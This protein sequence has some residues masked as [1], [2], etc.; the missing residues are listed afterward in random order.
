MSA[1]GLFENARFP[2]SNGYDGRW[3]AQNQMGPNVL[4][5]TEWLTEAMDLRPG[6]KVLDLGCGRALS[7]IFLAR[8]FGVTVFATDLWIH[9]ADN[10][11]RIRAAGSEDLVFPFRA[12][13][14]AL[15]FAEGFFDAIVSLDSYQYY[16]TDDL[17]AGYVARYL[18]PGGHLGIVVPG[19]TAEL[20]AGPPEHL[21]RPQASGKPFWEPECFSF[22]S[23]DWWRRHWERSGAVEV[24]FA[25]DLA[26]GWQH[27]ADHEKALEASGLGV[28]PSDEE[29][30][31]EDAGRTIAL[32]RVIGRRPEA[33]TVGPAPHAWEP[34]FSSVVS[35]LLGD[36]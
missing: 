9:A 24:E 15:P 1:A 4:W 28:F 31:R 29:A 33:A 10:L 19:L 36:R 12:E 25:G 16:G 22:H 21:L 34:A 32:V 20:E 5:L 23:A 35:D 8:E 17:Y 18:R 3:L 26:E 13:A 2:R 6:M 27:W 7:S 14:H 30:L 11:E